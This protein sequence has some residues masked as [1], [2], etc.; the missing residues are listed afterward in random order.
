MV[1]MAKHMEKTTICLFLLSFSTLINPDISESLFF[2]LFK[3]K[4]KNYN[5]M[6]HLT[7][8]NSIIAFFTLKED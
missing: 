1:A 8:D 3:A 6:Q 5:Q 2:I 7:D 4:L